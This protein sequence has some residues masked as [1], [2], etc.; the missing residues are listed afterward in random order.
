M[1]G[2]IILRYNMWGPGAR[3][4]GRDWRGRD[5]LDPVY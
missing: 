4:G 2:V 5:P 3:E 1:P